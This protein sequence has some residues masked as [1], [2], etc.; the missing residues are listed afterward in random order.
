[1]PSRSR[2]LLADDHQLVADAC[3]KVLESEFT[4]VGVAT[5]GETLLRTIPDLR[6]DVVIV[7]IGMPLLSGLDAAIQIHREFPRTKIIFLTMEHDPE[8]A[9]E[10]FRRGASGY[11]LKTSAVSELVDAVRE[12]LRGGSYISPALGQGRPDSARRARRSKPRRVLTAR[13]Q[14]VLQLLAQGR[15]M[16]EIGEL[17][18]L[19][20]RTVAFHKYRMME[21]L[22]LRNSAELIQYAVRNHLVA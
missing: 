20:P 6:P 18:H 16:K 12:V 7:D 17:L 1:M 19:T 2:V 11:L 3:R 22:Q 9:A 8:L 13:Q 15:S 10:A 14:E 4:V 21:L 5:D